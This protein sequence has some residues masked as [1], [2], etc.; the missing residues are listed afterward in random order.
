MIPQPYYDFY[1][2]SVFFDKDNFLDVELG[3]KVLQDIRTKLLRDVYRC[4]KSE[5]KYSYTFGHINKKA[6]KIK[7][8]Y[9]V[10]LNNTSKEQVVK[11]MRAVFMLNGWPS[12][13]GGPKW[14]EICRL[15][16]ALHQLDVLNDLSEAIVLVDRLIDAA[17]N[18]GRCLD[19]VYPKI[20]QWLDRKTREPY[21]WWLVQKCSFQ[22]YAIKRIRATT[23]LTV[24]GCVTRPLPL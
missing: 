6:Q 15:W 2:L 21:P 18:T 8:R 13:Y 1:S 17:H 22:D 20:N 9:G 16:V 4:I 10:G 12:C 23:G 24:E 14:S 7:K 11:C 19:K 5:A 3:E